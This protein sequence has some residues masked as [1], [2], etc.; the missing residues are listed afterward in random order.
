MSKL[1][2]T[3]PEEEKAYL[4][5]ANQY[6]RVKLIILITS[7]IFAVVSGIIVIGNG[8]ILRALG[9]ENASAGVDVFIMLMYLLVIVGIIFFLYLLISSGIYLIISFLKDKLGK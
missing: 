9:F 7:I 5:K 1:I 8:K 2:K 6:K 3:T 4:K